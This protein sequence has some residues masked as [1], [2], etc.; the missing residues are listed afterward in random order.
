ME[1]LLCGKP[2][3]LTRNLCADCFAQQTVLAN[4]P[5]RVV[6]GHCPHC[7]GLLRGHRWVDTP[8]L[9]VGLAG[10]VEAYV[11][12]DPQARE[13]TLTVK[14]EPQDPYS[15]RAKVSVAGSVEGVA[16]TAELE[17]RVELHRQVCPPCSRAAGGYYEAILQVRGL[18]RLTSRRL[19][20]I[21]TRLE[22]RL[23]QARSQ[24]RNFFVARSERVRGGLDYYLAS[25]G[26]ARSLAKGLLAEY[27]GTSGE[28]A[29]L[30]GRQEGR[31]LYRVTLVVRLPSFDKGDFLLFE[32]EPAQLLKL[33]GS[34]AL[35]RP[36]AYGSQGDEAIPLD[37]LTAAHRLGGPELVQ[38]AQLVM[39]EGR[40]ALVLDPE[41]L[42]TREVRLPSSISEN[43]EV[44][45][46][47]VVRH[48]GRLY[49]LPDQ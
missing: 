16:L 5:H 8:D 1:C 47:K 34:R 14:I 44:T 9:E 19:E 18:E 23:A 28:S 46:L 3:P 29:R 27:G 38:K 2:P 6:I 33:E 26:G 15:R 43:Q 41:T 20:A 17:C 42:K 39:R 22:E 7:Q 36:L 35:L 48:Q 45:E 12:L 21:A 32:G 31:N 49:P 25:L 30:V 11:E 37:K 4:L 10:L 13:V 24:D 40:E